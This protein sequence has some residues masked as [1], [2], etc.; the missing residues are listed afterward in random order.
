MYYGSN[1][2][3][4]GTGEME[5]KIRLSEVTTIPDPGKTTLC[6]SVQHPFPGQTE[7]VA[8]GDDY[9]FRNPVGREETGTGEVESKTR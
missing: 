7:A 1:E 6:Y 3:R 8:I 2:R 4:P 9:Y 5:Q